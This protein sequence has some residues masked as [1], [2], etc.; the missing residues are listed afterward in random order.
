[1][2]VGTYDV[3]RSLLRRDLDPLANHLVTIRLC[4]GRGSGPRN[5]I[6]LGIECDDAYRSLAAAIEDAPQ[7]PSHWVSSATHECP[8]NPIALGKEC[9]VSSALV[10]DYPHRTGYRVRQLLV[11]IPEPYFPTIPI[12]LGSEC[13]VSVWS[14]EANQQIPSHWVTSATAPCLLGLGLPATPIALGIECDSISRS[15]SLP[16]TPIALGIEC[17][18]GLIVAGGPQFCPQ[19]PSHWVSSATPAAISWHRPAIPIP[20]HWV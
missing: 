6:A 13:D 7:P 18:V 17:D 4:G 12:A 8:R 3:P 20:S 15:M 1:L 14:I 11:H 2:R 5:P 9:D 19:F 10:S 16:A